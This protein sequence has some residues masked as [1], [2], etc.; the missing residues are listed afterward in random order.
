MPPLNSAVGR[1]PSA[2]HGVNEMKATYFL[3]AIALALVLAIAAYFLAHGERGS[4]VEPELPSLSDAT[5]V[6]TC[7]SSSKKRGWRSKRLNTAEETHFLSL[8]GDSSKTHVGPGPY[9]LVADDGSMAACWMSASPCPDSE[10][11]EI[12]RVQGQWV[13][14][15]TVHM[16]TCIKKPTP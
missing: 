5:L 12:Y 10:S 7:L 14:S 13:L 1:H 9:W 8:L 2:V 4:R 11:R 3:P 15:K 6:G 16:T